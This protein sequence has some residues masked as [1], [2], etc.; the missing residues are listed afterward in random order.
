MPESRLPLFF[1]KLSRLTLTLKKIALESRSANAGKVV[2]S[3]D[4][5]CSEMATCDLNISTT[6]RDPLGLNYMWLRENQYHCIVCKPFRGIDDLIYYCHKQ[7][8]KGTNI[9]SQKSSS[10]NAGNDE[11]SNFDEIL[12]A[13]LTILANMQISFAIFVIACISGHISTR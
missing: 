4:T 3:I 11:F 12:P 6:N 13:D 5:V 7:E 10:R 1:Y 2:A 8:K 9:Y